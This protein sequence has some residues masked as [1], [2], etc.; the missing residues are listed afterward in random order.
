MHY[1]KIAAR[2]LVIDWSNNPRG[3]MKAET[4]ETYADSLR[5]YIDNGDDVNDVWGQKV[6]ATADHHVIQGCHTVAA[7]IDV[8]PDY[9]FHV[10]VLDDVHSSNVDKFRY[11]SALSNRL[12]GLPMS[13]NEKKLAIG[14]ILNATNLGIR[15]N[16]PD[17]LPHI[18]NE[19]LGAM[20]NCSHMTVYRIRRKLQGNP[21]ANET[22]TKQDDS[23]AKN[24]LDDLLAQ[25]E[26]MTEARKNGDSVETA[27]FNY[28]FS[29]AD[30]EIERVMR[31]LEDDTKSLIREHSIAELKGVCDD[32]QQV[33]DFVKANIALH[34]S[35]GNLEVNRMFQTL[36]KLV[37]LH[38]TVINMVL[39]CED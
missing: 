9:E 38:I 15:D 39:D 22:K 8:D 13:P 20:M 7:M 3:A 2:N 14:W 30:K 26:A 29:K 28:R 32:I 27:R 33:C 37:S 10:E 31:S 21:I 4:K 1:E 18:S 34:E 35:N 5:N 6:V 23:T 12:H 19:K 25:H 24:A 17:K 11:F 16:D 36:M